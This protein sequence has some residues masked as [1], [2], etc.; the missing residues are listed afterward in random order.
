[1]HP[2]G[3]IFW[4][5]NQ[6]FSW[7][8]FSFSF[9]NSFFFHF[10]SYFFYN[11]WVLAVICHFVAAFAFTAPLLAGL[12]HFTC[13]FVGTVTQKHLVTRLY[14]YWLYY[15]FTCCLIQQ[16]R[17][18]FFILETR[19]SINTGIVLLSGDNVT[20][21]AFIDRLVDIC[22]YYHSSKWLIHI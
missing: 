15:I 22:I 17:Y 19:E 1:M 13:S 8:F 3:N 4:L 16:Q 20:L 2:F 5:Q 11:Y 14:S 9:F 6:Q 18:I 7:T 12:Q 10:L 21:I